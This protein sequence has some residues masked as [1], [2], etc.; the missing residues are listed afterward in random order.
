MNKPKVM[1]KIDDFSDGD[2]PEH[3]ALLDFMKISIVVCWNSL[4]LL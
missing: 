2:N 1:H 4:K 3:A